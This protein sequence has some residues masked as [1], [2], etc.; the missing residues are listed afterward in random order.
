MTRNSRQV[1]GHY[2]RANHTSWTP[3]ALIS[4]D[5]ETVTRTEGDDEVLTMRLW[6]ARFNDRRAPKHATPL[7]ET[8]DGLI[9]EDLAMQIHWW[10]RQRRTVWAYAHNL[11]FDL[12]TSSLIEN[13][14]AIGWSVT[15]FAVSGTAPFIRMRYGDHC[16][17]LSDSWSWFACPLETVGAAVGMRKLNLPDQDDS[18]AAWLARCNRDVDILHTAML[19]LMHWWE[20]E[21]LGRW[22]ITGSASGWNAM[23]HIPTP[24]RILVR[25]DDS[26][27]DA[28]RQAIYGGRRG[29]WSTGQYLRGDYAE[30][31]IAK[32]YTTA[33]RDLP[34]PVGRHVAFDTLPV[35]HHWLACDRWGV[36]AECVIRT[37]EACVPV[38]MGN[39]V[40]YPVGQFTTTLAGPDIRECRDAGT[41]VSVGQGWLH[42]LGYPLRPWAAWCINALDKNNRSV[43][44]VAKLVHKQWARSAVGKWNQRGFEQVHIGPS[45]NSGW[46]YEEAWHHEKNVPAGIVDFAGERYQVAAVNQSDNAYP[47]ILAFVE[48][49]VR[50]AIGRAISIVGPDNMVACDTDGYICGGNDTRTMDLVNQAIAPFTV[51]I[52]RHYS[53]VRVTGPQ[54]LELDNLRRRSGIPSSARESPDGKLTAR[55]WPKL[56][57]QL[58][59]GRQGAYVRPSQTYRLAATYAP[60]WVLSDGSVVPVEMA[61]GG[62]GANVIVPFPQTRYARTGL[63]LGDHQNKRLER[64][65]N[66]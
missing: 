5:T 23:R 26:E 47:A 27:C 57:W 44:D 15:E 2:L 20:S 50:V 38:R 48:S 4:F 21:D 13:L 35:D 40:W 32:A 56:A 45:P 66:A 33:C 17:T 7:N 18:N 46:H 43:P 55:T 16:L 31:D 8:A 52:K 53:K 19:K 37:Q 36:I 28:D 61:I 12:C 49:Y 10:C 22:N 63:A 51:R 30:V 6:C 1:P 3:P 64:Y 29:V 14:V 41:L 9:A 62:D 11:G 58:A 24:E 54:H 34:L 60:G 65:R 59:N 42:K 25:P 39:S